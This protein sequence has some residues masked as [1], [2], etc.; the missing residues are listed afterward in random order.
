[1]ENKERGPERNS[2]PYEDQIQLGNRIMDMLSERAKNPGE[3]FVLLQQLSVY[4]WDQYKIDWS[5]REDHKVADTRKQRYLDYISSIID[6]K[7]SEE[8]SSNP[9][10]E[11]AS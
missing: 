10:N 7:L 1:M 6:Q 3:A 11:N 2:S 8:S 4:V 9:P 5:D